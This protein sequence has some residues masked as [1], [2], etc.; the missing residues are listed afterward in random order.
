[1]PVTK[2]LMTRIAMANSRNTIQ[3]DEKHPEPK[4]A[5]PVKIYAGDSV[6][7]DVAGLTFFAPDE[8]CPFGRAAQLY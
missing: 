4:N 7:T 2:V 6:Q 8:K 5:E 1:M 3:A